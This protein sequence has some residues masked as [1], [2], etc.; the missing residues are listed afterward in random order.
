MVGICF[1][2]VYDQISIKDCLH[3]IIT[4]KF[5][6]LQGLKDKECLRKT[7]PEVSLHIS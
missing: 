1:G 3:K 4:I 2:L 7:D 5:T 6:N